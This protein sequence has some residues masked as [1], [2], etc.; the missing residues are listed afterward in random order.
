M[1]A[2][3]TT[4]SLSLCM[5][6]KDEE[7]FLENCLKQAQ[8]AV[9]E[10][11]IVDTGSTDRTKKIGLQYNARVFDF[12]W[13]GSFAEARNYGIG[14]AS[15]AWILWLDADE[16][17]EIEDPELWRTALSQCG[18]SCHVWSLPIVNYYGDF[19]IDRNKAYSL[20]QYRLFRNGLGLRFV[21]DIHEQLNVWELLQDKDATESYKL[22]TRIHHYGYLESVARVKKKHERN[23]AML[24]KELQNPEHSP[25]IDYHVASEY[26]R[27]GA[28][29]QVFDHL[30]TAIKGFISRGQLPPSL[31]YKMKYDT[32][33]ALGSFEGAWLGIDKAITLY[34]DYVDLHYYKGIL[35]FAQKR[36]E[37]AE[38]VFRHCLVL[39]ED[40][41]QYLTLRGAGSFRAES[42]I[43]RCR[44][45]LNN[46]YA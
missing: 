3:N 43:E 1:T 38:A 16:V 13:T 8:H 11:I 22:P 29:K 7:L 45:Y 35:L 44:A 41:L 32:L 27:T 42:F 15:G 46:L 18:N 6:V 19:P 10:I 39:G 17:L 5:I 20:A 12:E 24:E 36:Y 40:N 23:M 37:E 9:D 21:N 14:K 33:L 31:I 30:N 2:T 28:Y 34:P 4:N 25:W 26:Y